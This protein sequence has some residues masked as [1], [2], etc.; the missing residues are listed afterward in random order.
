MALLRGTRLGHFEIAGLLGVGGMGEVYRAMDT[1]LR[2]Q[3]AIKVLPQRFAGYPG[4]LSRFEREAHMLASLNHPN[5]AAIYGLDE[6]SGT[7]FLVLE[8]VEGPTVADRLRKGPIP[9]EEALTIAVQIANALETAHNNGIKHRDL[10]PANLKLTLD[11]TVKVL[12][13]GLAAVTASAE[14][15]DPENSPTLTIGGT[16]AGVIMGTTGYMSPEQARGL[17]VDKRT[18]IWA[19][20]VVLYE[21]VTGARLFRGKTAQDTLASVLKQTPDFG[22]APAKVRGLIRS[23]LE[24]DLKKRLRDIGDAWHLVDGAQEDTAARVPGSAWISWAIAGMAGLGLAGL[25]FVHFREKPVQGE[26]V[27]FEIAG[28]PNARLEASPPCRRTAGELPSLRRERSGG[29]RFG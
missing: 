3:V 5:I 25:A 23:C 24:K 15:M 13:F 10:K 21:M 27:R 11:G 12:D 14:W 9:V 29:T 20:G 17:P 4:R 8:L 19:F 18:D 28:P 7:N 22:R 26:L 6:S 2:R 1:K 16:E